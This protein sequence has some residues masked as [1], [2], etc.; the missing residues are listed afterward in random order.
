MHL[1]D[2]EKQWL[3]NREEFMRRHI[4][5]KDIAAALRESPNMRARYYLDRIEG[6]R[7]AAARQA[8]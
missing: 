4:P 2:E 8:E 6:L 1:S 3:Q 7:R 5:I